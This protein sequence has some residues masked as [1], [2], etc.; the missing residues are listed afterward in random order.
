MIFFLLRFHMHVGKMAFCLYTFFVI[1]ALKKKTKN[2]KQLNLCLGVH[3]NLR[4]QIEI[5]EINGVKYLKI[6]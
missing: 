4:L 6:D 3:L 2:N 1:S 5:C